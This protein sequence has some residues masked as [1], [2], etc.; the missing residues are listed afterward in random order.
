M[1][2]TA[3]DVWSNDPCPPHGDYHCQACAAKTRRPTAAVDVT[4]QLVRYTIC[5]VCGRAGA[6][7]YRSSKDAAPAAAGTEE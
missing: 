5:Q 4:I 3:Y 2:E 7:R 1:T 6:R